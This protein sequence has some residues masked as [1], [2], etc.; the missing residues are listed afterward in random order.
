MKITG[1]DWI[2]VVA[3]AAIAISLVNLLLFAAGR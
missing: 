3:I 2:L 1:D